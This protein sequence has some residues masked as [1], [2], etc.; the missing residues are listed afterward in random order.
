MLSAAIVVSSFMYAIDS[1]LWWFDSAVALCISLAL[2]CGG[3]WP[4]V[5]AQWWS[6]SFWAPIT[7][8][9]LLL[10]RAECGAYGKG[11]P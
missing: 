7:E 2:F 8:A 5:S 6:P 9:S 4:L 11:V 10:D 1:D 3:M